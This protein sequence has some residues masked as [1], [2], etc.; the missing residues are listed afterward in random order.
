M[1]LV[2]TEQNTKE[3]AYK[4]IQ[5]KAHIMRNMQENDR[6]IAFIDSNN[7]KILGCL[8]FSDYDGN[9]IFVH[10]A[11]DDPKVCQRRY[12]KLMFDYAFNQC[13]CNRMTAMCINGYE[14]NEKLLKGVG[15][16]K[17]GIIRESIKINN[18]WINAALYGIL[19]GECKW[20]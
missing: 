13:K 19:K 7:N 12:I 11:L 14:R 15:F 20:V 3:L 2:N 10:L 18:K 6:H 1:I 17:E 16:V 8:L 9:N 5:P 4:W